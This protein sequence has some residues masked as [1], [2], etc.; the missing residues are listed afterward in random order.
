MV[1]GK[2]VVDK[3]IRLQYYNINK[4]E[5]NKWR[6]QKDEGKDNYNRQHV[7]DKEGSN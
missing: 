3:Y 7:Y 2:K 6:K 1:S 5:T 4:K